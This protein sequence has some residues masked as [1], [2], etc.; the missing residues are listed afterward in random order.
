M[1]HKTLDLKMNKEGIYEPKDSPKDTINIKKISKL[2]GIEP[3]KRESISKD[4]R[5]NMIQSGAD[6]FLGGLDAGL[7]FVEAIKV[8]AIRIMG[9]RD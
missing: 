9:L 1:P 5:K 3:V 6:E 4:K 7:D 8:R 2:K